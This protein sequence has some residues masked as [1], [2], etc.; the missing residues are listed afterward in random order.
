MPS[1][2][3]RMSVLISI[4]FYYSTS[5]SAQFSKNASQEIVIGSI[6]SLYSNVLEEQR[7]L[8]IHL[9]EN[10]DS[11]RKYPVVFLLDAPAHF[12]VTAGL[13]KLLTQWNMPQSFLVGIPNTDRTRDFTP[14]HVPF[15]RGRKS[16]TSGGAA[17][18][19][20]FLEKELKPYLAEK[21]PVE[22]MST[23]V[24]HSTGGLFVVYTYLE[25]PEVFDHYLALDPSLWWD[26]E[27]LVMRSADLINPAKHKDKSLYIAAAN[28]TGIDSARVRKMKSVPTEMLRANLHF[29]D[30]L[31]ENRER[32]NFTW[33]YYE[34]EDHGSVVFPGLH[35]GLRSL[36]SWYPFPERW[37]F[38]SPKQYTA[39]QLTGPFFTH[40]EKLS[41]HFKREMKPDWQFINDVGFFMLTGHNLPKKALAY[42]EMN[43]KFYPQESRSYVA[44]G[45][46][47]LMRK[48]KKEALSYFNK[49]VALDGNPEA[50]KKSEELKKED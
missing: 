35:N 36:Y 26:K 5:I 50:L 46:Y 25:H 3:L 15:Q 2:S 18:F 20:A 28:S 34:N 23:L 43:L 1:I 27:D 22:D 49:A 41:K 8:W 6:D 39:E 42:L 24:G 10:M 38:N 12:Y 40:F 29:H 44:L 4:L 19:L 30:V 13:L 14:T 7:E 17:N 21:Y 33:D 31:V 48:K 9:P 45:D 16:P 11:T 47:Y 32:L 37:R